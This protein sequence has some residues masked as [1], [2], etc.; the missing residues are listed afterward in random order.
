MRLINVHTLKFRTFLRDKPRYAIASHRWLDNETT[1]QDFCESKNVDHQG[2]QK[3]INFADYVRNNIAG[4]DWLWIDTCCINKD[5]STELQEAITSMF[6]WYRDAE[7]CLALLSDVDVPHDTSEFT[8]SAWFTRGWTLQELLASRFVVFL[9]RKWRVIGHKG[10]Q[11]ASLRNS[12]LAIGPL[13]HESISKCTTIP[14]AVLADFDSAREISSDAKRQ[15]MSGRQTTREEDKVYALIGILDL[16]TIFINYGEGLERAQKRLLDEVSIMERSTQPKT[17]ST[18]EA[19]TWLDSRSSFELREELKRCRT[20]NTCQ[21]IIERAKSELWAQSECGYRATW[22]HGK[23]GL[24]KSVLA[25]ALVQHFEETLEKPVTSFFC[26]ANEDALRI[27]SNILRSCLTQVLAQS[28]VLLGVI[29]EFRLQS[30][31][32][33]AT[34]GD[35]H[36]LLAR[37][38]RSGAGIVMVVDGFDECQEFENTRHKQH[39]YD[40]GKFLRQL[41]SAFIGTSSQ[42]VLVSRD[43]FDIRDAL[44]FPNQHA[45]HAQVKECEVLPENV[46]PDLVKFCARQVDSLGRLSEE[47]R[48]QVVDHLVKNSDGMFAFARLQGA[49]LA[50]ARNAAQLRNRMESAPRVLENVYDR[51]WQRIEDCD[52]SFEKERIMR[53]LRWVTFAAE[54]LSAVPLFEAIAI[55]S[56]APGVYEISEE[57]LPMRLITERLTRADLMEACKPF[58]ILKRA[59]SQQ[60]WASATVELGHSTMRPFLIDRLG[61]RGHT[62]SSSFHDPVLAELCLGYLAC[63]VPWE[64]LAAADPAMQL[65]PLLPYIARNWSRHVDVDHPAFH[66]ARKLLESLLA[67]TNGNW[68]K[69]RDE[70]ERQL[71]RLDLSNPHYFDPAGRCYYAAAVGADF[72]LKELLASKFE[73]VNAIGGEF[74]TALKIACAGGFI[75]TAGLLLQHGAIPTLSG[76]ADRST[77]IHIAAA[78]DGPEL[79]NL[80]MPDCTEPSQGNIVDWRTFCDIRNAQSQTPL[81]IAVTQGQHATTIRLINA[82]VDLDCQDSLGRTALYHCVKAGKRQLV[83]ELLDKGADCSLSDLSGISPLFIAVSQCDIVLATS[84]IA[85]GASPKGC[86]AEAARQGHAELLGALLMCKGD[87]GLDLPGEDGRTPLDVVAMS[88]RVDIVS[89]LLEAGASA[90]VVDEDGCPLLWRA[91]NHGHNEIVELLLQSGVNSNLVNYQ[92]VK[93]RNPDSLLRIMSKEYE[94]HSAHNQDRGRTALIIAASRNE[95]NIVRGLLAADA[96]IDM[97]DFGGWKALPVAISK[98]HHETVK[99]LIGAGAEIEAPNP[100]GRPPLMLALK[101]SDRGSIQALVDAN[102]DVNIAIEAGLTALHIAASKGDVETLEIFMKAGADRDAIATDGSTALHIAAQY[103]HP[104]IVQRLLDDMVRPNFDDCDSAVNLDANTRPGID[105]QTID[106]KCTPLHLAASSG[107]YH[108]V[109]MLIDAGADVNIVAARG[110]TA[111]H[112][113]AS[114]GDHRMLESLLAADARADADTNEG[115]SSLQ[116]AAHGGHLKATEVLAE[117]L[118]L[119]SDGGDRLST[120]LAS[121]GVERFDGI[122]RII[123]PILK[124]T[125]PHQAL[126]NAVRFGD[127]HT[128]TA[129]LD[130][131]SAVDQTDE[132]GRTLLGIAVESGHAGMVTILLEAGARCDK[133]TPELRTSWHVAFSNHRYGG[134][135]V[136]DHA[137]SRAEH[138]PIVSSASLF[139]AAVCGD[140]KTVKLQ[141]ENGCSLDILRN[142]STNPLIAAQKAGHV[143][144]VEYI[145]QKRWA[146]ANKDRDQL[147]RLRS[148]VAAACGLRLSLEEPM[149]KTDKQLWT[150]LHWAAYFGHHALCTSLIAAGANVGAKDWQGWTP[151]QVARVAGYS[152]LATAIKP[153]RFSRIGVSEHSVFWSKYGPMWHCDACGKVGLSSISQHVTIL[154]VVHV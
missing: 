77:A 86:F 109:Q 114:R 28:E 126:M 38:A 17:T 21:W 13:L 52:D 30:G 76:T 116:M 104:Q 42:L 2:H 135:E 72:M 136:L 142:V 108:I 44:C 120:A 40:R 67:P 24:G 147:G 35:L 22:V 3:I 58:L 153:H 148:H 51:Y 84:L 129:L 5:S 123:L 139:R 93:P 146:N 74:G 94:D 16:S 101:N 127:I 18:D 82:G 23:L 36:N 125:K 133:L 117:H 141:L 79:I 15:W 71:K 68:E 4:V 150:P 140:E 102:A 50:Q 97:A 26:S 115:I 107:Y 19:K 70:H 124:R 91:I 10:T 81:M 151:A 87:L 106:R 63:G 83:T 8:N 69:W 122:T 56:T 46:Q 33:V 73:D 29:E 99:I 1:F 66:E 61:T 43:E 62:S 57:W 138:P 96:N 131:D 132:S 75:K 49:Q 59:H 154:C 149:N 152:D 118:A 45:M 145:L 27:P 100:H 32:Q 111:L 85:A 103:G 89:Q 60:S 98:T 6:R 25:A 37:V 12:G 20:Q 65:H 92:I 144:T 64:T 119:K 7:I 128:A 34:G 105:K 134:I 121:F 47:L 9:T 143:A 78:A 80:L 112:L 137:R 48:G 110:W 14:A 39:Q 95:V 90:N 54:P 113:A 88:G 53:V 31:H 130:A 11:P 55:Q 41:F